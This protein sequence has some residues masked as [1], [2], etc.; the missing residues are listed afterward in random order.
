MLSS[1][2]LSS[3][4]A[5]RMPQQVF[6]KLPLSQVFRSDQ[7]SSLKIV[8]FEHVCEFER[9]AQPERPALAR[10]RA[11]RSAAAAS[12]SRTELDFPSCCASL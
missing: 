10:G 9:I 6:T 12:S 2:L 7:T 8:T 5:L 1:S 4:R 11:A 3:S